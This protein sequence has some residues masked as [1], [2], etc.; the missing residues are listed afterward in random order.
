MLVNATYT[1]D[2][3]TNNYVEVTNDITNNGTLNVMNNG[4]LVQIND[5]GVNT[6]NISYR[7]ATT[8][9]ALD[10]VYWSSP[11][12]GV[13]T[14][15]GYIY[16]WI[17]D[18]ANPNGGQGNW[19]SAA[20]TLMQPAIGYIMRGVLSRNFIGVPRNGVYTPTIKEVV[21]LVQVQ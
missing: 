5:L 14:P 3:Q 13:N 17:P 16:T 18:V 19:A 10:Y 7:R 21:I 1:L 8:G 4:S 11:V 9:V 6:G 12:D 2:I 20:N 15:S